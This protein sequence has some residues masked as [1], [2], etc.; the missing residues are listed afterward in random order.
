MFWKKKK[1][2]WKPKVQQEEVAYPTGVCVRT[3]SATYFVK[4]RYKY[5]IPSPRV[6]E[7]WK[8]NSVA[9]DATSLGK[10][11]NGG[12]LGFRDGTLIEN[13]ADRKIYL[14]TATEK[15]QI[16]DPDVFDKY[17]LNRA[18]VLEVSK[19]EAD[20]HVEGEVLK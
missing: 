20:L 3:P 1:P 14:I 15:R 4:G 2:E 6:L 11:K 10:Y 16:V 8:F 13:L 12:T 7:S 17:G 9:Q 19:E 5:R 18:L